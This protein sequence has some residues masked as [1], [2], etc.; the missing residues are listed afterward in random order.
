MIPV[1]VLGH[2]VDLDPIVAVARKF[3]LRV[4]EDATEGLGATYK[5]R[6]LGSLR[7]RRMFQFQ[8]EQD[9]HHGRRRDARHQTTRSGRGEAKYL[10]TQAKDDPIEYVHGEVGYNYRLTNLLAAVGC[11]QMEQLI[12]MSLPSERLQ[13]SLR[14][15]LAEI[16]GHCADGERPL[17]CQYLLDVHHPG[18][19]NRSSGW[20]RA[21]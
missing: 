16:P 11:A 20:I 8:R 7:R 6:P 4:I 3:G 21:N 15:R 1:H 9:H 14:R 17:G 10:T 5:G 12:P 13:R 18:A 2:P 19:M